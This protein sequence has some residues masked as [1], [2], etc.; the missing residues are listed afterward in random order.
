V[1]NDCAKK[2][3]EALLEITGTAMLAGD[4]DTFAACF[5]LPHFISTADNKTVLET[6]ED[7]RETF[8]RVREDYLRKQVTDMVRH[9]DVAAFRDPDTIAVAHTTHLLSGN[10]RVTAP[11]PCY[12]IM[13]HRDGVWRVSSSQYAV[14]TSTSVGHALHV[15]AERKIRQQSKVRNSE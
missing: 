5:Q 4:F 9:C 1:G 3:A 10:Y 6:P 15:H 11:Y 8:L 14:D 13:E 2:I 12:S 7:L